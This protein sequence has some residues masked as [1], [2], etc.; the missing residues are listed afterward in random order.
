MDLNKWKIARYL[1]LLQSLQKWKRSCVL[2][3]FLNPLLLLC[4]Y[5]FLS[6]KRSSLYFVW[7]CFSAHRGGIDLV[8]NRRTVTPH[9]DVN[10]SVTSNFD[11]QLDPWWP[12]WKATSTWPLFSKLMCVGR[13]LVYNHMRLTGWF[14]LE[15]ESTSDMSPSSQP[16]NFCHDLSEK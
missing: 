10:V 16:T 4:R 8:R 3:S 2:W 14:I 6:D 15:R 13:S 12:G 11:P 7:K 9:W 1:C 5:W